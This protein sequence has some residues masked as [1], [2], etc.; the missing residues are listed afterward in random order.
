MRK[1]PVPQVLGVVLISILYSGV[2]MATSESKF[3]LEEKKQHY[4]IRKYDET[5]QIWFL[6]HNEIWIEVKTSSNQ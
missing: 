2:V 3:T 5:V 1:I 6:R 4:E